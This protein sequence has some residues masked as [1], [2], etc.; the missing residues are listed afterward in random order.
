MLF[1]KRI[2]EE[3]HE[4]RV[5]DRGNA[6]YAVIPRQCPEVT[7]LENIM[8]DEKGGMKKLGKFLGKESMAT[9]KRLSQFFRIDG[10]DA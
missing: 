8:T 7:V 4:G 1:S 9:V 10:I 6:A 3:Q 2:K 5:D